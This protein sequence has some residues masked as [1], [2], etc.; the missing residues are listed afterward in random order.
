MSGSSRPNQQFLGVFLLGFLFGGTSLYLLN[1]FTSS[2]QEI[3][4]PT[5]NR[6]LFTISH[7]ADP[8]STHTKEVAATEE[9]Q[10]SSPLQHFGPTTD[11]GLLKQLDNINLQQLDNINTRYVHVGNMCRCADDS[12]PL[13]EPINPYESNGIDTGIVQPPSLATG[14]MIKRFVMHSTRCTC[15]KKEGRIR[16]SEP[17]TDM[18]LRKFERRCPNPL[19][20]GNYQWEAMPDLAVEETLPIFVG[21]LSYESPL[22]LNHT[23]YDWLGRDFFRRI[24]AQDV[25]VQLNHRSDMDDMI[26]QQFMEEQRVRNMASPMTILGSPTDNLHPGLVISDMCR[27]AEVHPNSHPNG[28][29][30]LVFL[31]K[32]WNMYQ[33]GIGDQEGELEAIFRGINAIMQRGVIRVSLKGKSKEVSKEKMWNCPSQGFPFECTTAHQ[34]RWTNQPFVVNCKWFLRNLEP[35]VYLD[36]PIMYG[37]RPGMQEN[38]YCDWEEASQDGRI[39]WTNSHWVTASL[40]FPRHRFFYHNEVDQ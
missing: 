7:Y 36:D 22:S 14:L 5:I 30:L 11:G 37:C 23:L 31:E 12:L 34:H 9:G 10:S 4:H 6:G 15:I 28:E 2:S 33:G 3:I 35:F 18:F 24:H 27:R 32:D 29:N 39:A 16:G 1:T 13:L 21:V 40:V 20:T 26:L 19:Y 8:K 17:T 38:R 25:F